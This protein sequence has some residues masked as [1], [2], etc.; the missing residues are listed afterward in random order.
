MNKPVTVTPEYAAWLL[1]LEQEPLETVIVYI[2]GFF[3]LSVAGTLLVESRIYEQL[4]KLEIEGDV[5]ETRT[6]E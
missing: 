6:L 3:V 1:A 4:R 2:D 5:D